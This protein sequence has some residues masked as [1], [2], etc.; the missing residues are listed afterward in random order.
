MYYSGKNPL[1]KISKNSEAVFTPKRK[2]QRDLHKALLRYHDPMNWNL[3]RDALKKMGRTDLI[4]NGPECLVPPSGRS[5]RM[6]H[7]L[8]R[9]QPSR[10][11][12]RKRHQ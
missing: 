6:N 1:R 11:N 5:V 7:K 9:P 12:R 8:Q 2:K 10:K 4:G 3:I